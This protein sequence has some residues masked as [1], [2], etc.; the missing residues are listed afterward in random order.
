MYQIAK[1]FLVFLAFDHRCLDIDSV[2]ASQEQVV[3][4]WVSVGQEMR[5]LSPC[6]VPYLVP[7]LSLSCET[8]RPMLCQQV[9]RSSITE[10]SGTSFSLDNLDV[11][12]L[13][14]SNGLSYQRAMAVTVD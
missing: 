5:V 12:V 11:G 7:Y 2:Q 13:I 14:S 3:C 4:C 10:A 9:G 1:A 6:R 8:H